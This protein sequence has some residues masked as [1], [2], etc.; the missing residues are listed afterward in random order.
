M[1][2]HQSLFKGERN[3]FF[4]AEDPYHLSA[5]AKGYIAGVLQHSRA[6]TLV[7]NQWVNSYKRLLPGFEAP[8]YLSWARRNRSDLIRIP[9]YKPGREMHTR[10]EYRSPDPA[11][12]PYLAFAAMLAA[13]LDGIEQ[14]MTLP[15]P[16]EENV[17]EMSAGERVARGIGTL[18]GS[19][20]EAIEAAEQSAFLRQALGDH[21]FESLVANKRI[22]WE[23][24]RR[25]VSDF[26][27]AEYLPIL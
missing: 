17:F 22:E 9:E 19:L 15:A 8:V 23:R 27:L 2:V 10:I 26:E 13:G 7:C 24:Y 14:E 4:D 16:V 18:P 5:V 25:H 1:H 3:A 21:T 20:I 6:M 11:C 12:N